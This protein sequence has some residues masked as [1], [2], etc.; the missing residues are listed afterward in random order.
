MTASNRPAGMMCHG[1]TGVKRSF[2]IWEKKRGARH[3][4]SNLLGTVG[5]ALFFGIL[6]LIG[7]VSLSFL[8]TRQLTEPQSS[9]YSPGFGFWVLLLVLSSFTLLGGGGIVHALLR[10]GTSVERRAAFAKRAANLDLLT[11]AIPQPRDF[12][13]IPSDDDLTNSPGIRLAFRLPTTHSPVWQLSVATVFC[14]LWNGMAAAIFVLA[15]RTESWL[16]TMLAVPFLA[17]GIWSVRYFLEQ[18]LL[19]NGIGPT[20][21]EISDHPLYP[22]H[23][24]RYYLSQSGRLRLRSLELFLVCEEEATYRQGTDVR[25]S[26]CVVL[27]ESLFRRDDF[28]IDPGTPFE[29]ESSFCVPPQAIHSF[30]SPHNRVLWKLVVRAEVEAWPILVRAFPLVIYPPLRPPEHVGTSLVAASAVA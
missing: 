26:S 7:L 19:H 18:M 25:T 27:E 22:G 21:L 23:E 15:I 1:E 2:R 30:C 24:Y 17:V 6:A 28:S 12:P 13:A 29:L 16:P 20:M 3:T 9:A 5:E 10:L 14:L 4:G 8:I 11:D